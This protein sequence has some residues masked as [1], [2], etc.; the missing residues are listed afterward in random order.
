MRNIVR[1]FV[2]TAYRWLPRWPYYRLNKVS[3]LVESS[4]LAR[5]GV[6][7]GSGDNGDN[8]GNFLYTLTWL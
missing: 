2:F 6:V 4:V 3:P 1:S 8:S 7:C 5:V